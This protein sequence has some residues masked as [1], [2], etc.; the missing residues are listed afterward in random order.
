MGSNHFPVQNFYARKVIEDADGNWTTTV[1]PV[2][3]PNHRD[4]YADQCD[5]RQ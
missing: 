4:P 2:V 5:M 3:L 1:G